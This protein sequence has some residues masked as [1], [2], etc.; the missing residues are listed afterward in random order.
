MSFFVANS[1]RPIRSI[2][3][4]KGQ[5]PWNYPV[6][7]AAEASRCANEVRCATIPD[8]LNL[9]VNQLTFPRPFTISYA[10]PVQPISPGPLAI[11]TIH[12]PKTP[13]MRP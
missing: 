10:T 9:T 12:N 11:R 1:V 2:C 13:L 6:D 3:E 5:V 7:P 8:N 4:S